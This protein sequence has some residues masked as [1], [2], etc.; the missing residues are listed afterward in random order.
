M[1][2]DGETVGDD[3]VL[4]DAKREVFEAIGRYAEGW[5]ITEGGLITKFVA[6]AEIV[7]PDGGRTLI[8]VCGA[9][10][11]GQDRLMPWDR[12]GLLFESLH[13]PRQRMTYEE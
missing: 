13:D 12:S 11:D 5:N 6:F 7:A 4:N 2:G 9:G 1:S 10:H 3:D 8:E